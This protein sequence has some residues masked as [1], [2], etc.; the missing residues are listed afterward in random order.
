MSKKDDSDRCLDEIEA[1]Y[2]VM[3]KRKSDKETLEMCKSWVRKQRIILKEIGYKG[4]IPRQPRI[5]KKYQKEEG[6]LFDEDE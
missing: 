2:A 1:A 5:M 3:C 4:S 6:S